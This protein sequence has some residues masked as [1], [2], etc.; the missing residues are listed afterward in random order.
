MKLG[1]VLSVILLVA[2]V[3]GHAKPVRFQFREPQL[4][5]FDVEEKHLAERPAWITASPV[6]QTNSVQ[7][8]ARVVLQLKKSATLSAV[9][10]G[11]QLKLKRT[12]APGLYILEASDA[13]AAMDEAQRLAQR[14]GVVACHPVM[15]REIAFEGQYA[16]RPNDYWFDIQTYHEN[17]YP[18]GQRYSTDLN[19]L[20]A[21]PYTRGNGVT[22]A[23]ADTGFE[24][25]HPDLIDRT[26]GAPHFNFET[27]ETN[28]MPLSVGPSFS[29]GTSVAGLASATA[30]NQIGVAGVA[31]QARLASW[32]IAATN[33]IYATNNYLIDD[34]SLM[35]LFQYR[36]NVVQV[37]NH[38]WGS[39]PT[40]VALRSAGILADIGISNAVTFG[41]NGLGSIIV[42]AA[43]N[44]RE[45]GQNANDD[46]FRSTPLAICT[47][48]TKYTGR[49]D[50]Y[51][52]PGACLLVSGL[53]GSDYYLMTTDRQGGNGYNS[54]QNWRIDLSRPL[55]TNGWN[56]HFHFEGTSAAAPEIS[57]IAALILSANPALGYRDVQQI[58]VCSARH[59]DLADPD[60]MTNAAGFAVSH[61]VGFGIPDAGEAVRLAK[62]WTNRPILT[63]V[64]L[65][66][67]VP[68]SIPDTGLRLLIGGNNI[69]ANLQSLICL[70]GFGP[71]ADS[72]TAALPLVDVGVVGLTVSANVSNKA[73]LIQHPSTTTG[74]TNEIE[75]VA[76]AGAKLAVVFYPTNTVPFVMTNTDFVR[77]PAVLIG[78]TT[79]LNLR[80]LIQTNGCTAQVAL[81]SA[82]MQFA[83]T[84]T[85]VCEH[86]GVRLS[87]NYPI[88]A[89]LRITLTSPQGTRSV[90]QQVNDDLSTAPTDWT[91]WTTHDFYESS[92]GNWTL[93]VTDEAPGGTGNIQS[94]ELIVKGVSITDSD[95][96]GL[97]DNWELSNFGSLAYSPKDDSDKDGYNNAREQVLQSNPT[98]GEPLEV[99]LSKW[100]NTR[101]RLGW[102]G[103]TNFNYQVWSGTNVAS[104]GLTAT[105]AGQ[106]PETEWFFSYTNAAQFFKVIAQPLP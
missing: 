77:I 71:H 47:A 89:D 98:A 5:N 62:R 43:G 100:T 16:M 57:G 63:T 53:G 37:Q 10:S 69:P 23:I 60:L 84:N 22:I 83:V 49:A 26:G 18:T 80:S 33:S 14:N 74:F 82:Q 101:A 2:V 88:R 39:P 21:W 30:N 15:R 3:Q 79:G 58:L 99:S 12:I 6:G 97:D 8:G 28:G 90:F 51:S 11:T 24:T 17:R 31:P 42:R 106:F 25:D 19:T 105:V 92:V 93:A 34:E 95:A 45:T 36:S 40:T 86:V 9:V 54:V 27:K 73:A 38:S 44:G 64:V 52:N 96:D 102:S 35:D 76:Q 103:S 67:S 72:P 13:P 85:L 4:G 1:Q 50:Y 61:N 94:A 78:N 48:A 68:V 56:Y 81:N 70:P 55:D 65:S 7:F 59:F 20:A 75:K 91:Y 66:N 41:R 46:E 104:L 32:V 87:L 29:H